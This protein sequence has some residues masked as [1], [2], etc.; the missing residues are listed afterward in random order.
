MATINDYFIQAQL[1]QAA[2]AEGF[3]QG[4]F[5]GTSADGGVSDYANL[6]IDG[7]M[8]EVQAKAFANQ[9][10]VVDQYTDPVSGFSCAVFQNTPGQQY[11]AIRGTE[12]G[13]I[14]GLDGVTDGGIFL[15]R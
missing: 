13:S 8:S 5:G 9:Y 2:Y 12:P 14:L 1:S 10:T 4:M 15:G 6:L 3:T 7:G 11:L